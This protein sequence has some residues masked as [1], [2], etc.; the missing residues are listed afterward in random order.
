MKKIMLLLI[1]LAG[2]NAI[3][4]FSQDLMKKIIL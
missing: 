3:T 2:M 4:V 1:V